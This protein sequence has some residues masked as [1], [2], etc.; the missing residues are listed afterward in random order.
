MGAWFAGN[1]QALPE[2]VWRVYDQL[3]R[4][5][6]IDFKSIDFPFYR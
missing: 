4:S 5:G 3:H 1:E 2:L 6:K